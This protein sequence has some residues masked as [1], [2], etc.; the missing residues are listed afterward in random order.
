MDTITVS[1]CIVVQRLF[2]I[3]GVHKPFFVDFKICYLCLAA[4]FQ[5]LAGFQKRGMLDSRGYNLPALV[6]GRP[7]GTFYRPVVAL[8]A[9]RGKVNLVRLCPEKGGY[10]L[11]GFVHRL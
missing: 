4:F 3:G 9:A 1:S 2:D 11:A 8:G 6:F 10:F 7:H 5:S